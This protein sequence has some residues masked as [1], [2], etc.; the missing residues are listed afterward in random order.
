MTI[1]LGI[2]ADHAIVIAADTQ[3]STGYIKLDQLKIS[4]ASKSSED[5]RFGA[6]AIT[7]AGDTEYLNHLQKEFT[8]FFSAHEEAPSSSAVEQYAVHRTKQFYADHVLPFSFGHGS[9]PDVSLVL[10]HCDG[11]S[12]RLWSSSRNTVTEYKTY[13]AVGAGAGHAEFLLGNLFVPMWP[14][15]ARAAILLAG[16]V[17]WQVKE[18]IE[19]CGKDMDIICL[20]A[21]RVQFISREQTKAMGDFFQSCWQLEASLIEQ[22]FKGS[23]KSPPVSREVRKLRGEANRL[24]PEKSNDLL[25]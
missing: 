9:P 7:G 16:Y 6:L 12:A 2:L 10:G 22:I 8:G 23:A 20:H 11:F 13:T 14:M 25:D 24:L 21:D 1:A 5:G 3:V 15:N 17:V 18:Y 19:S 4:F